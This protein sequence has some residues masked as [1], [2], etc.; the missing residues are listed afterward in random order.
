[1]QPSPCSVKFLETRAYKTHYSVVR[2]YF[3]FKTLW[4]NCYFTRYRVFKIRC[5]LD[6]II[7]WIYFTVLYKD[8]Y[9]KRAPLAISKAPEL[10]IYFYTTGSLFHYTISILQDIFAMHDSFATQDFNLL[11][12]CDFFSLP[13]GYLKVEGLLHHRN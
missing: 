4:R 1:M 6:D 5:L 9:Q 7:I 8:I 11:K 13:V 10:S 12:L 2:G 3:R